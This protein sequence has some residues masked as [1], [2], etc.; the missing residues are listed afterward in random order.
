VYNV[1]DIEGFKYYC[2][3]KN[4]AT[5]I[6]DKCDEFV[7]EFCYNKKKH[8]THSNKIIKI[9][10]YS[11]YIKSTLKDYAAELDEKIINDEFIKINFTS[12]IAPCT[13]SSTENGDYLYLILPVRIMA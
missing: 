6:C 8:I 2:K 7:C 11:N 10:E 3:Y 1:T 5:Y 9:E 12:P 4:G 13:I